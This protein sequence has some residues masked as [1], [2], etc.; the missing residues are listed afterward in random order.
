MTLLGKRAVVTGAGGFLGSRVVAELLRR[1]AQ[2]Q[3]LVRYQSNYSAGNLDVKHERVEITRVDVRDADS[4]VG[5]LD[6]ADIVLHL[7]ANVSVPHSFD[8]P[9]SHVSTNLAGT[10]N[11]LEECR[12]AAVGRVVF[13][14]SS[15][16]YGTAQ[17]RKITESH[18][19]VAQSPYAASKIAAE[20]LCES[21][22]H[23]YGVPI[24][25]ARP[26]NLYG[27]QQSMRAVIP[28]IVAQAL[29]G[30]TLHLGRTDTIRDFNYVDDTSRALID[31]GLAGGVDGQVFNIGTGRGVSIREVIDL[32]GDLLDTRLDVQ[33][34][35]A[36]IRP[37]TSEVER[38]CGDS[39]K[40]LRTIPDW[41]RTSFEEGIARVVQGM[42][43]HAGLVPERGYS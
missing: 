17:T 29:A 33:S 22:W 40:L 5:Q 37:N 6:S 4:L 25:V 24:V 14:S 26:F 32:V 30:R 43:A 7:A 35:S 42:R 8:S 36:Y 27:P 16:V 38:L 2:V 3:A 34:D 18:P 11:V 23:A 10:L 28:S 13:V 20:K 41:R 1:G 15:E 12:R 19:L 21:Y 9:Q 39:T 31:L